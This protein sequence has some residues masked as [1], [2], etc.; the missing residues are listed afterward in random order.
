MAGVLRVVILNTLLGYQQAR[1]HE[2]VFILDDPS[3]APESEYLPD[4][5]WD[6]VR[7]LWFNIDTPDAICA[8]LKRW[9]DLVTEHAPLIDGHPK[10]LF[11]GNYGLPLVVV[12]MALEW[13]GTLVALWE[14][15]CSGRIG[16]L[17]DTLGAPPQWEPW[18]V[19][20]PE[21]PP[22]PYPMVHQPSFAWN[23]ACYPYLSTFEPP[24]EWK[25]K[26]P[27]QKL[28]LY[29]LPEK[30]DELVRVVLRFVATE[31]AERAGH[32]PFRPFMQGKSLA[33]T[34]SY[35]PRDWMDAA[36][37]SFFIE[38]ITVHHLCKCGCGLPA[39]S[40]SDYFDDRHA[41]RHRKRR[42]RELCRR[43][44][45]RHLCPTCGQQISGE[46]ARRVGQR[47]RLSPS[48]VKV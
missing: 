2:G 8:F 33:A 23:G 4:G 5:F 48:L 21:M 19:H 7:Q 13:F 43:E 44:E 40:G 28:P 15:A 3:F 26:E 1:F 17:R 37:A 42:Q 18:A 27:G 45:G 12:R 46:A 9:G 31:I 29:A 11:G 6:E 20:I 39:R 24:Y 38:K 14:N 35:Q 30:D 16:F 25:E 32:I 22:Q 47:A 10:A 34:W 36:I 41:A